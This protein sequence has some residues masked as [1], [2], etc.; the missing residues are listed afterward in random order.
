MLPSWR[1]VYLNGKKHKKVWS[2]NWSIRNT[3]KFLILNFLNVRLSFQMK[4]EYLDRV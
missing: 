2:L 1:G 4:L 3:K